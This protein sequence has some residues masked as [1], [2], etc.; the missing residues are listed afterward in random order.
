MRN[1]FAGDKR[2]KALDEI[3]YLNFI[4]KNLDDLLNLFQF[5]K[6]PQNEYLV[7]DDVL[8]ALDLLFEGSFNNLQTILPLHSLVKQP[9]LISKF[10]YIF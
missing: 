4:I 5:D 8:Q 9:S 6:T 7:N 10:V 3:N 2:K 1:E